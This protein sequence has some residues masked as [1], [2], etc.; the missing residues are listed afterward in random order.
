M[1]PGEQDRLERGL[2]LRRLSVRRRDVVFVKG[3]LEASEGVA[4]LFAEHGGELVL[5]AP[6]ERAA[7]LDEIVHDLRLEL[8]P[9]CVVSERVHEPDRVASEA[10]IL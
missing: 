6:H 8:G 10:P 1:L 7:A 5:A 2:T 3:I 4:S 9:E